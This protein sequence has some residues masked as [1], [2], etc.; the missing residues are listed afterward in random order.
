M[1][2][3]HKKKLRLKPSVW[4]TAFF[5]GGLIMG[6]L[7]GA[8]AVNVSFLRWLAFEV[9]FGI[10]NPLTIDLVLFKFT[11]GF[12]FYLTPAV[13]LFT[14]LFV[15]GG[16]LIRTQVLTPAKPAPKTTPSSAD[17]DDTIVYDD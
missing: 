3:Q 8:L 13:V 5:I 6:R 7:V 9:G 1:A 2:T 12:G 16:K 10:L 17:D 14:I 4:D 15:V 11:F